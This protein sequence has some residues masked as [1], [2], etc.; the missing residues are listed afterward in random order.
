MYYFFKYLRDRG[1]SSLI[2]M[3]TPKTR[4]A[5]KEALPE[6]FLVDGIIEL[7][8]IE[9]AQDVT[10]YL[11]VEKM[12]GTQHSTKRFGLDISDNGLLVMGPLTL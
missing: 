4:I 5:E 2:I 12:R 6:F 8:M 3:E 9:G 10:R 7:G 11:R 1:L